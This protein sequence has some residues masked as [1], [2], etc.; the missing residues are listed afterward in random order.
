MKD[1]SNSVKLIWCVSLMQADVTFKSW[2]SYL[3]S[4][5]W[6]T[7]IIWLCLLTSAACMYLRVC[8]CW[9]V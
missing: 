1:I 4:K 5:N 3:L 9:C 8:M 2:S 7:V 6:D